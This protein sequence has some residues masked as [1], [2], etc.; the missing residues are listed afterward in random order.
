MRL[1]GYLV[2]FQGEFIA[3][4]ET[5]TAGEAIEYLRLVFLT[6]ASVSIGIELS[7]IHI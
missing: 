3:V 5:M 2:T 4:D 1:I 6:Y 7:L